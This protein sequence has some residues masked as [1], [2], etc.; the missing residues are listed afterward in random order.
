M[1]YGWLENGYR[2]WLKIEVPDA[3]KSV[4]EEYRAT[5]NDF[6]EFLDSCCNV[7]NGFS[8]PSGEL[9]TAYRSYATAQGSFAKN[10]QDFYSN[11]ERSG[12]SK[13][14]TSRGV[15]VM[16]L[17]LKNEPA[18]YYPLRPELPDGMEV[19]QA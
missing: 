13:H 19:T 16:G 14:R 3:V 6:Q 4:V 12:F 9:Y 11:L 7:G 15:I 1:D 8:S 17:T 10:K 5:N 2:K 18:P